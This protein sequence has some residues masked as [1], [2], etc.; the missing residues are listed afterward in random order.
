MDKQ[1]LTRGCLYALIIFFILTFTMMLTKQ[2]PFLGNFIHSSEVKTLDVR[3]NILVNIFAQK[4]IDNSKV[5]LIVIDDDSLEKLSDKYGYW[6][7]N[8]QSYF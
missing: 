1:K 2:M 8:R 3:E 6:P 7:W 5:A 4:R